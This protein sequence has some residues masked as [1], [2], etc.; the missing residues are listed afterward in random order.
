[1]EQ[2]LDIVKRIAVKKLNNPSYQT[3]NIALSVIMFEDDLQIKLSLKDLTELA[4]LAQQIVDHV[5]TIDLPQ[6]VSFGFGG[7]DI[8]ATLTA[9]HKQ[10]YPSEIIY[11]K[12]V[13]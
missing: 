9:P 4:N 1:M 3:I 11:C 2:L 10:G 5:K 7:N 12:R 13:F 8:Y 6:N